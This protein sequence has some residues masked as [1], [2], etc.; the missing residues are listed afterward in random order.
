MKGQQNGTSPEGEP[1]SSG[2]P[3]ADGPAAAGAA[4]AAAA[5]DAYAP[6]EASRMEALGAG[7]TS[8]EESLEPFLHAENARIVSQALDPSA[9]ADNVEMEIVERLSRSQVSMK[10]LVES[11]RLA[12][13]E[14]FQKMVSEAE[15]EHPT[16]GKNR[17]AS[18]D[19]QELAH[20]FGCTDVTKGLSAAQVAANREK[21]GM[22]TLDKGERDPLYKIFFSQFWSPVV[23]LLLVAAEWVEGAAILIIVTLNACLATYM[24]NS[25]ASEKRS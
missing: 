8:K 22:N 25:G 19:V 10:E 3:P 13:P 6:Q 15:K 24:E 20:E 7:P 12:D 18:T 2:P 4:A 5:G 11:A 9:F 14:A 21:Y 16:S 23:L 17:F 1:G